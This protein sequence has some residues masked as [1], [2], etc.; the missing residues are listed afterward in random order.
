MKRNFLSMFLLFS[1]FWVMG[2]S[3]PTDDWIDFGSDHISKW[4]QI[5]PAKLG[6]NALP[7]PFLDYA[8]LDSLSNFETG[9]H[10]H[11]MEGDK[12]VNTY[13]SFYWAVVPKR[14]VVHL[15]GN[16]TE[17]FQTENSVRDDR[18]I[19][20]D[21]TGWIT[22][23]GD[24]WISTYIQIVK[25]RKKWPD[26]GINYTHKTTTG[27]ATQGRYTDGG[28]EY[29]Y[30]AFGKSIYPKHGLVDEVRLALMLGFYSWQTNKVEMAQDDG[31]LYEFGLSIKS[32][33]FSWQNEIAGLNAYDA[34]RYMNVRGDN[35]PLIIRSNIIRSGKRF[36]FKLEYQTG[37][38]D[39]HYQ[40]F[41]FTVFYKFGGL[42]F[43][44]N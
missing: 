36:D 11:L 21:D 34:Y 7:V 39:Y 33:N 6:P 3:R 25:S 41:R 42:S 5:A 35:D 43:N 29:Y 23:E 22:Q 26:I 19:Y 37:L 14:V 13:L 15:W 24:L 8:M 28:A 9:V 32:K 30:M 38:H 2:Q 31:G 4:L 27:G 20:Y 16:P 18:Q 12:V 40:T 44:K 17:T 10:T 1:A